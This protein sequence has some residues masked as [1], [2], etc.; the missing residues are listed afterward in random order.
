MTLEEADMKHLKLGSLLSLL[1]LTACAS[2]RPVLDENPKYVKVGENQAERDIDACMSRADT[3]LAKHREERARKQAGRSAVVGAVAGGAIGLI[4]GGNLA[5]TAIG[6][7]AG[8][9]VGAGAGYLGEKSKDNL[10]PDEIK[11][12]YVSNCLARKQYRVIGWK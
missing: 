1:V 4:S 12:R 3:F 7:G 2:Y 9:A 6:T 5:S 8:A 10:T 11:Q